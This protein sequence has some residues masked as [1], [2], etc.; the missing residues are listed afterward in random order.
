MVMARRSGLAWLCT[1]LI[2]GIVLVGCGGGQGGNGEQGDGGGE[3]YNWRLGFNTSEDSVRDIAAQRFKE[4]VEEESDGRITVEI[5]PAEALGS[6][7]EMLDNVA[8]GSLDMQMAGGPAMS[9]MIPEYGTLGLPFMVE[10]F[11]EAYAVLDGPVGDDWKALAEEQGYKVLSHHDLGFAQITN[12]VRPIESPDDLQGLAIRSPE[13]Q[14]PVTTFETLGAQVSTMP[15]TEVY[16]A[17]Q[18]GVIDGQFNPLDA[19]Y[20][21]N[22]HEVQDYLTM[23]NIF[24]YHVNFIMNADLWESLDSETQDI[25][26]RAA[27]ESQEVSRQ[28]TQDNEQEM[29]ETLQGEFEEIVEEPNAEAF[30]EAVEPAYQQV[31]DFIPPETIDE[32]QQFIEEYRSENQ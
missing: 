29:R 23:A 25:V 24:Y 22:F 12:N 19:I 32:T 9:N 10:D 5:F 27:D 28:T 4:V 2:L 16:P 18:Q 11:D 21:T 3:T 17:L 8:T 20:E 13:E 15:F 31:Q 1:V 26:Q 14:V 6:E 7:Q 30:Q